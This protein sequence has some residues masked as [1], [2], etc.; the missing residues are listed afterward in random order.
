[1]LKL[2]KRYQGVSSWKRPGFLSPV[3]HE[4]LI[5]RGVDSDDAA[6]AF[7]NPDISQLHN[8]FLMSDMAEAVDTIRDAVARGEGICV[9]GDYDVDG[10]CAS[11]IVML[12]LKKI[13]YS[14]CKEYLPSRHEEGYGLNEAA[15]D[16]ISQEYKLMVSVDCGITA[17]DLVEYAKSKGM[18]VVITDHHRP[19]DNRPE[20]PVVNPL[21][22]G[23]AFGYL[24]GAGVAFKLVHALAAKEA[25]NGGVV[26]EDALRIGLDTALEYIDLAALAT[27]ADIVK[28]R[29][30]NRVIAYFGLKRINENMRPGIKALADCAALG[31]KEINAGNV[32]FQ[33]SPRLNASGRMGD[34][35]RAYNL[36]TSDSA[37]ECERL[38]RIL[39]EENERRKEEERPVMAAARELLRDYD[40]T[41]NRAI[42]LEGLN[43]NKGVIGLAA[44]KITE[45]YGYP[46]VVLTND[47]DSFIGSCRSLESIDIQEALTH[48]ADLLERFGGHKMAAGLKLPAKN[49]PEFKRRLNAYLAE[50]YPSDAWMPVFKYD[51][52]IEPEELSEELVRQL[53]ELEPTGCENPAPVFCMTADIAAQTAVGQ[54]G[55]HLKLSF[56][57]EKGAPIDGIWFRNGDKA[58]KL[59]GRSRVLFAPRLNEWNRNITVQADVRRITAVDAETLLELAGD[60]AEELFARFVLESDTGSGDELS[61]GTESGFARQ[62]LINSIQGSVIVAADAETARRFCDIQCDI[63][64]GEWSDDSRAFNQIAL[65]PQGENPLKYENMYLAGVP[66]CLMPGGV[67]LNDVPVSLLFNR[68][69]DIDGLRNLFLIIKGQVRDGERIFR[70]RYEFVKSLP[71]GDVTAAALGVKVLEHTGLVRFENTAR[72]ITAC[73][74]NPKTDGPKGIDTNPANDKL[75]ISL[76]RATKED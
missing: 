25:A 57:G 10:V 59:P 64:V 26:T 37:E 66:A 67:V 24:C 4:L 51:L 74:W 13:G 68:L 9:Y 52:D 43:W 22:D 62:S 3:M 63:S 40:F 61:E 71:C 58:G 44:S 14:N 18:R 48:A 21:L 15:I 27:I 41:A 73:V 36:L 49:L 60:K 75:Y 28:L 38:A 46:S 42:I 39:N 32:A 23:Y 69:P 31:G 17:H 20:C 76:L 8:P 45:E 30:E 34:A 35:V 16:K 70:N 19:D 55:A 33:L 5:A 53:A 29:D 56:K 72:G 12:Y 1:M 54:E 11:S 7:L 6:Q 47:G 2:E 50:K 65:C